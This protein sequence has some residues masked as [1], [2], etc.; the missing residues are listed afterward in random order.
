MAIG[1]SY[2]QSSSTY[3]VEY[4]GLFAGLVIAMI[5]IIIVYT[6]FQKPLQ[7]GIKIDGGVKG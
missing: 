7:E 3:S 6:I 4:G 1:L 5:P 2:L